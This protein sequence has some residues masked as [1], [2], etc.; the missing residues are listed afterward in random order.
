[1]MWYLRRSVA[2]SADVIAS[3]R[4][5]ASGGLGARTAGPGQTRNAGTR[6]KF[7]SAAYALTTTTPSSTYCTSISRISRYNSDMAPLNV[8]I[9][10]AGRVHDVQLDTDQPPTV[11]KNAIYQVTG[12]PPERMKVMVKGGILKVPHIWLMHCY[13][14]QAERSQCCT[15]D[16]HDWKKVAPKEVNR[17]HNQQASFHKELML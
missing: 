13:L 14:R 7:K 10:H 12:V 17:I 9:K 3:Y 11:F 2:L 4:S 6:R 16:D 5:G 15:Q 1:M 8:H